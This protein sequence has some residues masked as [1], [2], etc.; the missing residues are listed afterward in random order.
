M[1]TPEDLEEPYRDWRRAILVAGCIA[2]AWAAAAAGDPPS[3]QASDP[4]V[5]GLLRGVAWFHAAIIA[6]GLILLW[7][8][9]RFRLSAPWIV[10]YFGCTWLVIAANA[11]IWQLTAIVPAALAF[12][13]GEIILLILAW[14]DRAPAPLRDPDHPPITYR[15][16]PS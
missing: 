5:V 2:A 15:P 13:A 7:L 11:L 4:A 12:Y 8:R 10:G 3:L 16:P 1:R 14:N 6:L 9:L